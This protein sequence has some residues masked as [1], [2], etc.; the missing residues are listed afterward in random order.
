MKL[1]PENYYTKEANEAYMSASF[2]KGMR[3]CEAATIAE[4]RGEYTRESNTAL[5]IGS[6][7]DVMLTGTEWDT[8]AFRSEHPEMF[9]K[10]GTLKAE[11]MKAED[12]VARAKR[13]RVFM[14]TMEG[15][16]QK[17]RTGKICGIPFKAKYDVYRRDDPDMKEVIVDL[18]TVKDFAPVYMPGQGRV[19]F[20]DAWDWP[21]Q[22]AIY[23]QLSDTKRATCLLAVI[24]KEDPPDVNV[25][26][27]PQERLDAEME[28]LKAQLPR[29]EA[30]K[31]GIIPPI[32]CGKCAYCR[33]THMIT[34]ISS[35]DDFEDMGGTNE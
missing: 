11:Y 4:L 23:Q 22:M 24:S 12:M 6:Y 15:D 16:Y 7:V 31:A 19:P 1:T 35:L 21:L 27:I 9:K 3:R 30:V 32:R 14:A 34:N 10:D 17:I 25:V 26:W 8:M 20:A 18:K 2:V 28:I 33:S 5:T 29:M 13:D